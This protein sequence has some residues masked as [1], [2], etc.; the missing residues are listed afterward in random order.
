MEYS[1]NVAHKKMPVLWIKELL[2]FLGD[3]NIGML[4]W[5]LI[6]K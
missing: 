3:K 6:L 4:S 2:R 5:G 1:V